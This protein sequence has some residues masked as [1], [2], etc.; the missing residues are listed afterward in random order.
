MIDVHMKLNEVYGLHLL[1]RD[2]EHGIR[3]GYLP[4]RVFAPTR[5]IYAFF[6]FNT[7]YSIDWRASFQSATVAEWDSVGTQRLTEREKIQAFVQTCVKGTSPEDFD[8]F[9]RAVRRYIQDAGLHVCQAE[10]ELEG[11]TPDV[12][13]SRFVD[14]FREAFR[15]VVRGQDPISEEEFSCLLN[16]LLVFIYKV[17]NNVFHGSKTVDHMVDPPQQRRLSVYTSILYATEDLFFRAACKS[18]AWR[19]PTETIVP[20]RVGRRSIQ[21]PLSR[22][23]LSLTGYSV[24]DGIL[25]YPCCGNDT[26]EPIVLFHDVISEFHFV[27][28]ASIPRLPSI[29]GR[30]SLPLRPRLVTIDRYDSLEVHTWVIDTSP[31]R[32]LRIFCHQEDGEKVFRQ[33]QNL[34][35]FFYRGDSPGEGG[36]GV[37]WLGPDLFNAVVEKLV[38]GGLI[39]TDGSNPDP[40]RLNAP[41]APLWQH[42]DCYGSV[43]RDDVITSFAYAGRWFMRMPEFDRLSRRPRQHGTFAWRVI[44]G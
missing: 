37:W 19:L 43:S 10:H 22:S 40:R 12:G 24:P 26:Y 36:S 38:D 16:D 42:R 44:R 31:K 35:V 18:C 6:V 20:P 23:F 21:M 28:I 9:C 30:G 25:F 27:D 7:L 34:S 3:K 29:D 1:S 32:T 8:F 5:F 14:A 15:K 13:T 41:W 2:I 39:V 11:I 17:R 4:W 33:L